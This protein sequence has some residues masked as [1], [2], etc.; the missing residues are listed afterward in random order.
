MHLCGSETCR[1]ISYTQSIQKPQSPRSEDTKRESMAADTPHT[2]YALVPK[3]RQE[4]ICNEIGT[5]LGTSALQFQL[6]STVTSAPFRSQNHS[7]AAFSI[8]KFPFARKSS[9]FA[10]RPIPHTKRDLRLGSALSVINM[11]ASLELSPIKSVSITCRYL[12]GTHSVD[13]LGNQSVS[14]HQTALSPKTAMHFR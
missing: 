3:D 7:Y 10:S 9:Y 11:M 2:L 5:R 1:K 8:Y 12:L 6:L 13:F 14:S 4:Q